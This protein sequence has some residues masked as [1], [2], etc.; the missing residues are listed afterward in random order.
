MRRALCALP[1]ALLLGCLPEEPPAIELDLYDQPVTC[2]EVSGCHGDDAEYHRVRARL[3]RIPSSVDYPTGL[4][5]VAFQLRRPTGAV[6]Q[7]E[8]RVPVNPPGPPPGPP[9]VSYVEYLGS[10]QVFVADRAAGRIELSWDRSC[11]CQ[12]GRLELLLTDPGPD[13]TPDTADDRVRRLSRARLRRGPAPFCHGRSA[14]SIRPDV[15]VV[16]NRTCPTKPKGSGGSGGGGACAWGAAGWFTTGWND[17]GW[18]DEEWDG[19]WD[20]S[21]DDGWEEESYTDD[22]CEDDCCDDG[23]SDDGWS[24]DGWSDDGW[25][26]DDWGDDDWG[27]DD[28]GDDDWGDDDW[29]DD[30]W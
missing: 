8:I 23:W 18:Y 24:D 29:G 30:D 9:T 13:G 5:A 2:D 14:L 6:A 12:T 1:L 15:L 7:V 25:S 26:D 11:P 20:E 4:L 27:D 22:C 10:Q 16:G 3:T 17:D 19:D 28:W 21:F